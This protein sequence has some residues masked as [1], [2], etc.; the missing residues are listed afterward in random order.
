MTWEGEDELIIERKC[1]S[2]RKVIISI[3]IEI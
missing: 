2:R 3:F 1:S